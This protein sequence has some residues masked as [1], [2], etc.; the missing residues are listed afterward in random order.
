MRW[1]ADKRRRVV[2]VDGRCQAASICPCERR[3]NPQSTSLNKGREAEGGRVPGLC[4][5]VN[6]QTHPAV[7]SGDLLDSRRRPRSASCA[8]DTPF[9]TSLCVPESR[10]EPINAEAA[11]ANNPACRCRGGAWSGCVYIAPIP[12]RLRRRDR[13]LAVFA[14]GRMGRRPKRGPPRRLQPP[15]RRIA[16]SPSS[17]GEGGGRRR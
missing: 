3:P 12:R 17:T 6:R 10:A 8:T 9:P 1:A 5:Y 2:T 15:Q 14:S 16:A 4:G 13:G 11:R 7:R